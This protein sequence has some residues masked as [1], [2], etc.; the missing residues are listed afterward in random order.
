MSNIASVSSFMPTTVPHPPGRVSK[1]IIAPPKLPETQ[2][3]RMR[4]QSEIKREVAYQIA[5]SKPKEERTDKDKQAIV[6]Y[7]LNNILPSPILDTKSKSGVA[8][9]A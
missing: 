4:K 7:H 5:K 9:M 1:S 8:Y 3:D 2:T 6:S